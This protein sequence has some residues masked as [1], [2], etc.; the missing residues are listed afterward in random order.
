MFAWKTRYIINDAEPS[1]TQSSQPPEDSINTEY[2][3]AGGGDLSEEDDSN[4]ALEK[5]QFPTIYTI[6]KSEFTNDQPIVTWGILKSSQFVG[7]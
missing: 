5:L 2:S 1:G 7:L 3:A 6:S 4:I